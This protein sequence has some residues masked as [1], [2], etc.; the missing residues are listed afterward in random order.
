MYVF[1]QTQLFY[2]NIQSNF[3]SEELFL[4]EWLR[5]SFTFWYVGTVALINSLRDCNEEWVGEYYAD[6]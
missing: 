3:L 4:K 2:G 6:C 5:S 1:S